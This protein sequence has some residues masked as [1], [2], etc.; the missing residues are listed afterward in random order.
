MKLSRIKHVIIT[1]VIFLIIIAC[2]VNV[3][4]GMI[5]AMERYMVEKDVFRV[6]A[7][8]DIEAGEIITSDKVELVQIPDFFPNSGMIYKLHKSDNRVESVA[9]T[10]RLDAEFISIRKDDDLWAIGKV[11][12]E[13]I[14]AGE[15]L[16]IQKL[17]EKSDIDMAE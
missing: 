1:S 11:A 9:E 8:R 17:S 16:R 12:K 10:Y 3:Y 14:Y 5:N 7:T 13:K 4:N 6:I 2:I 15:I